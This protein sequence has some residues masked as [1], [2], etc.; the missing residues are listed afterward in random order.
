[1][2]QFS[3]AFRARF[4]EP[5]RQYLTLIRQ[6]DLEWHETRLM[7]DGF[8]PDAFLWR[9]RQMSELKPPGDAD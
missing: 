1:M 9:Q 4:G 8:D 2:S 3:R 7:A 6:Q 5:P